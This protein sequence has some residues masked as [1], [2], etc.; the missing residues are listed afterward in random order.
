MKRWS[1]VL[2]VL[3]A[4][5]M[6]GC[7]WAD[8]LAGRASTDKFA[9]GSGLLRAPDPQRRNRAELR[10]A[11]DL[12]RADASSRVVG[13]EGDPGRA[14]FD[15]NPLSYV[16]P[17]QEGAVL[18]SWGGLGTQAR[19]NPASLY[20]A[21]Y[22][23]RGNFSPPPPSPA[24]VPAPRTTGIPDTV[25]EGYHQTMDWLNE[26]FTKAST[27]VGAPW[28]GSLRN[29]VSLPSR[30]EG[31][32]F[33][34]YNG[35]WGTQALVRGLVW[36]G[37][38]MKAKGNPDMEVWDL[39]NKDGGKIRR[40]RSHQNG[41]DVDIAFYSDR[42]GF[43]TARNWDLLVS[44]LENPHFRVSNVFV[45][46]YLEGKLIRHAQQTLGANHELVRR[47]RSVMSHEPHHEDHFHVRIEDP[48]GQPYL[49]VAGL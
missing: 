19:A 1:L 5:G 26:Q 4:G 10:V 24:P 47:A 34:R 40:H 46:S 25:R 43:D 33:A 6:T 27:A 9:G 35:R 14:T 39:S 8:Q 29:A 45:A 37:A 28:A 22:T 49:Q 16:E 21:G 48:D 30:G 3:A 15:G 17:A 20:T 41:R 18:A 2:A 23:P 31:F 11:Q 7:E 13:V 44:V 32:Y 42:N 36:M 12:E 38:Q